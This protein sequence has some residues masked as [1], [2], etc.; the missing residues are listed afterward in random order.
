[1]SVQSNR[2]QHH[3]S[4]EHHHDTI[5]HHRD[6]LHTSLDMMIQLSPQHSP[7]YRDDILPLLMP[8]PCSNNTDLQV[9]MKKVGVA[10]HVDLRGLDEW[11]C[12]RQYCSFHSN[13]ASSDTEQKPSPS[14]NNKDTGAW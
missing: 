1:M 10:V 14:A 9:T 8:H 7:T 4:I 5:I 6:T 2:I 11:L 13:T 3:H 12:E